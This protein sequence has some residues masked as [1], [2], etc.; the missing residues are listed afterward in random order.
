MFLLLCG[1]RGVVCEQFGG[2]ALAP[3][4]PEKLVWL[5][6]WGADGLFFLVLFSLVWWVRRGRA[7]MLPA[8]AW[9]V[10]AWGQ[11]NGTAVPRVRET[12]LSLPSLPPSLDGYRIVQV[13]DLH[14]SSAARKWRTRAVVD[15]VNALAPDLVCLTG[16]YVDGGCAALSDDLSPISGLRAK[17]GVY[18]VRGN[19]EY[20]KDSDAW[21]RWFSGRGIRLLANEC[22]F[23]RPELALGGVNDRPMALQTGDAAPDVARTFASAT[24]G[25]F[26]VLMEHRPGR[27]RE[28]ALRGVGLQLSGHTHGGV[29]PVMERLVR[30]LNGGFL[31][32]PYRIGESVL[33]VSSGCGQWAGFPMRFFAPSEIAVLTLRRERR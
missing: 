16:D 20:Y 24:N 4:L 6:N 21:R 18:G 22:V 29:A 8:L 7:W 10:A 25:E 9:G 12:E 1:A 14:C 30:R 3:D 15:R 2:D 19:H 33:Y 11:Y 13:S 17:D 28:N 26:R 31:R 27:A 5:L 32:G 23:P